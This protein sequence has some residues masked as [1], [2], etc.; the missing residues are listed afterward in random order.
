MT[1]LY[2]TIWIP[3]VFHFKTHGHTIYRQIDFAFV[4][5]TTGNLGK[6]T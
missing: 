5:I 2:N 3:D 1:I 4:G 6:T